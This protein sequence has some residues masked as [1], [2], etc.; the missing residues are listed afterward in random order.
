MYAHQMLRPEERP[1]MGDRLDTEP[2]I[3]VGGGSSIFTGTRSK[4]RQRWDMPIH[5]SSLEGAAADLHDAEESG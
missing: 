3:G 5:P 2:A 4:R 1:F